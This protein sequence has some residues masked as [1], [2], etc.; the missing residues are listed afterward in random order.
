M[1]PDS[2]RQNDSIWT[3]YIFIIF[4]INQAGK[5]CSRLMSGKYRCKVIINFDYLVSYLGFSGNPDFKD[6]DLDDALQTVCEVVRNFINNNASAW[7]PL[8]CEVNT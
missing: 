7:A 8:I 5:R 2:W 1:I 6:C 3:K 4:F